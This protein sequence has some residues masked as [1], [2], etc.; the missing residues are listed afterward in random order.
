MKKP[1]GDI[2]ILNLCTTND[3]YMMYG[4]WDMESDRENYHFGLFFALLPSKDPENHNFEK[5]KIILWDN[6][7][8][9]MCTIDENHDVWFLRY[10]VRQTE[11]F[12]I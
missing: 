10:G 11:F 2:I 1:H 5:M 8:L 9:Q 12:V 6:I 3:N 4:S 7:T